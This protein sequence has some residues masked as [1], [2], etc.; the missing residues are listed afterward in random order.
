MPRDRQRRRGQ[1]PSGP[2]SLK[3][4]CCGCSIETGCKIIAILGLLQGIGWLAI[5][6]V[7]LWHAYPNDGTMEW[8]QGSAMR[9][10]F[11]RT[12]K[13][14]VGLPHFCYLNWCLKAQNEAK[15]EALAMKPCCFIL[16]LMQIRES[17]SFSCLKLC[18]I[19]IP[20]SNFCW[21]TTL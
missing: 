12:D 5:N 2:Q 13:F 3:E 9:A 21:D 19:F 16:R 15:K 8:N 10:F 4:C 7:V 17:N 6:V 14:W 1:P 18:F 20:E 11:S